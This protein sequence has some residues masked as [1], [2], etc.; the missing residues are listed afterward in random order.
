METHL[1]LKKVEQTQLEKE[2]IPPWKPGT[3]IRVS[4]TNE[5]GLAAFCPDGVNRDTRTITLKPG[6]PVMFLDVTDY[7]PPAKFEG[8]GNPNTLIAK[9]NIVMVILNDE[10]K[11]LIRVHPGWTYKQFEE[12]KDDEA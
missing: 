10:K 12:V 7:G 5:R 2:F 4:T 6:I 8:R 11:Y 3:L 1:T 9:S